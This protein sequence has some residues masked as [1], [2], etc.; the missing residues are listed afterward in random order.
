MRNVCVFT[1]KLTN[2]MVCIRGQHESTAFKLQRSPQHLSNFV[3]QHHSRPAQ[4][5]AVIMRLAAIYLCIE[6]VDIL[7]K[8]D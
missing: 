7:R 5:R 2:R 8:G 1:S 4:T 6:E 3:E